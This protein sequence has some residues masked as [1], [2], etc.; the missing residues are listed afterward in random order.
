MREL[1]VLPHE[2]PPRG[3]AIVT[4][5]LAMTVV[6]VVALICLGVSMTESNIAT[7]A[8]NQARAF[9]AAEAG[10]ES[11]YVNLRGFLQNGTATSANLNAITAP[12]LNSQP[13]F[14]ITVGVVQGNPPGTPQ[15]STTI[16]SGS[17]QSLIGNETDY[18]ITSTATNS[19]NASVQLTQ[20]VQYTLI[21][22]FQFGVFYGQG[23]DL[24]MAP[25]TAMTFAGR[26]H[27]NSNIYMEAVP[28]NGSL[29]LTSYLTTA[30]DIYRY[31]KRDGPSVRD[32]NP[33]IANASGVQQALNFDHFNNGAN[34]W[35]AWT[36]SQWEAQALS[37]FGGTVLDSAMGVQQIPPPIPALFNNPSN[38]DVVSHELI[39][40]ANASDSSALA[41]AKLY[42]QAGL[43]I[44]NGVATV[45]A[46]GSPVSLA[47]CA[48][49][50]FTT[51]GSF[52]DGRQGMTMHITQVDIGLLTACGKMPA[53]GIL[54]VA[55]SGDSSQAVRL[56]DGATLPAGGLTV[57]SEDPVYIQGNYNTVNKQPASVM[58]DAITVL[59]NNWG[60]D[61]YD[62]SMAAIS[63]S[64][65]LTK[66]PASNTTVNAAFAL[67][68]SSE[69][70]LN[71]GNGQLENSIRFLENWS[72]VTFTYSGSIISLWHSLRATG[73]WVNSAGNASV[74]YYFPP[75]RAW[76]YDS[77]LV[78]SPP[79][80]TPN[81]VMI[82]KGVWA[83]K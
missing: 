31:L 50:T 6:L 57:V 1:P 51:T 48:A 52:Y 5:L 80:G 32:T 18:V 2:K 74:G 82:V 83:K 14:S 37:T 9:Y 38:P 26:V 44:M 53:N 28:A 23:V 39:E 75:T 49:G 78:T 25:G 71:N 46:N 15:Y 10:L 41:A 64:N 22:L 79:P 69:S 59:S 35:A 77:T 63:G 12:T 33:T 56:V 73:A 36:A 29:T 24:E 81:A 72:G 42:N 16:A 7:N 17:Y 76:S 34:G 58:G 27:A 11:A 13:G 43:V 8:A 30:G 70:T 66:Y 40:P 55:N 60:P 54:Y 62:T 19:K 3:V 68:P 4:A 67:G 61:G 47:S 20:V 21:P 65:Q 45:G